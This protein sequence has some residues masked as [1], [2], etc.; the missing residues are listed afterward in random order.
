MRDLP[1]AYG[2]SCYAKTW[3]CLLYTSVEVSADHN[4]P[5]MTFMGLLTLVVLL[6]IIVYSFNFQNL[7]PLCS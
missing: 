7:M 1:I 5:V 3:A 4:P 6:D 2:N